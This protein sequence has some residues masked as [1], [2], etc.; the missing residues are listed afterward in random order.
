MVSMLS[1]ESPMVER[2]LVLIL[3]RQE[4]ERSASM[5]VAGTV[6]KMRSPRWT[7]GR[8]SLLQKWR[9]LMAES[10]SVSAEFAQRLPQIA[11]SA[12]TRSADFYKEGSFTGV[13]SQGR[14]MVI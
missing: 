13:R 12:R 10:G 7:E 6:R 3:L 4:N 1:L 2:T 5:L 11:T 9:A 8:S 14:R